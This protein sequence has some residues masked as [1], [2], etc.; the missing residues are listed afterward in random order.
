MIYQYIRPCPMLRE[1]VRDY[2][3]AHFVFDKGHPI[4]FKAYAP[5]PE[6]TITFLPRGNLILVNPINATRQVAP[7][8]SITGQQLTRYNFHLTSEYMMVR[9]HFHPGALYR[10]LGVPLSALTDHWLDG[11]AIIGSETQRINDR[12]ANCTNYV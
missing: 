9:V 6:Q 7:S 5:K 2:L 12:L 11:E 1:F 8:I 4:P 3:I 10:L